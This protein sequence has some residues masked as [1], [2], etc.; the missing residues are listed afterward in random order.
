MIPVQHSNDQSIDHGNLLLDFN[1]NHIS[2]SSILVSDD[3][4]DENF[5]L[6]LNSKYVLERDMSKFFRFDNSS[7]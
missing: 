7:S 3:D 2:N 5:S 4:E 6:D 1:S